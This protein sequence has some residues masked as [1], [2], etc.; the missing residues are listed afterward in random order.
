M[1]QTKTRR[2]LL[3]EDHLWF[4]QALALYL[5]GEPDLHVVAQAGTLAECR[6]GLLD[7]D[8]G[9]VDVALIDLTLPDGD[10]IDLIHW[11]REYAPHIAVL[12]LTVSL[13]T[14]K[15][16]LAL[17]AGAEEVISKSESIEGILAA[18]RRLTVSP[19][20]SRSM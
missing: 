6:E 4:R 17:R 10:G 7:D 12:V 14:E 19:A 11:L 18:I 1:T 16:E 13:E 3:I 15:Y 2:L 5:D 20:V 9:D 8:L